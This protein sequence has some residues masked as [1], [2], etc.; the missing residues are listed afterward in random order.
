MASSD[1]HSSMFELHKNNSTNSSPDQ[2]IVGNINLNHK[3]RQYAIWA[4]NWNA[5]PIFH[6]RLY[7]CNHGVEEEQG[8]EKEQ[9]VKFPA[10]EWLHRHV[11]LACHVKSVFDVRCVSAKD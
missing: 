8:K 3:K 10:F 4:I 9:V 2:G 11:L 5:T 1:L 7:E 6:S